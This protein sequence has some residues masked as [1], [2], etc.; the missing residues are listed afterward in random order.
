MKYNRSDLKDT[1]RVAKVMANK[2]DKSMFV[3]P[4]ALGFRIEK[5]RPPFHGDYFMVTPAHVFE[6]NYNF[7]KAE[8]VKQEV[9]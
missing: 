1:I 9:A 7:Q 6:F 2:W 8:F 3:Y 4:T 5:T